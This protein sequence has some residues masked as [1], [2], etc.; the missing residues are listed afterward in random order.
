MR[1]LLLM[2]VLLSAQPLIAQKA[3][4]GIWQGYD[5]EWGHVSQKLVALAEATPE[6]KFGWRPA[7]SAL[8]EWG[9]HA[10]CHRQFRIDETRF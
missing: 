10:H 9:V 5:G 3:P 6:E 8:G 4:R 2:L 7:P 1:K